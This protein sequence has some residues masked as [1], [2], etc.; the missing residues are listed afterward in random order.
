MRLILHLSQ[1]LL[2][3]Y[4]VNSRRCRPR[5][6]GAHARHHA[7]ADKERGAEH[8]ERRG[9]QP[10]SRRPVLHIK[11]QLGEEEAG[12]V[13]SRQQGGMRRAPERPLRDEQGERG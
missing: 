10:S 1:A 9:R 3:R 5:R 8:R 11:E 2:S 7:D 4:H 13:P 6:H 12:S